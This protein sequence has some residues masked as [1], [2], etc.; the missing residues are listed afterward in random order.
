M[1]LRKF[2]WGVRHYHLR[3]LL[4]SRPQMFN[5]ICKL[6]GPDESIFGLNCVPIIPAGT[7]VILKNKN[8]VKTPKQTKITQYFKVLPKKTNRIQNRNS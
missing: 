7:V 1:Q 6:L 3:R 8:P 5:A 4:H 2:D